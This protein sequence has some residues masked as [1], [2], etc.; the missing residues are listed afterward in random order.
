M[1]VK[2]TQKS[3]KSRKFN[4]RFTKNKVRKQKGGTGGNDDQIYPTQPVEKYTNSRGETFGFGNQPGENE[5]SITELLKK[6]RKGE[7]QRP[8]KNN[9]NAN[10]T[11]LF[12]VTINSSDQEDTDQFTFEDFITKR[13]E[14]KSKLCMFK[15]TLKDFDSEFQNYENIESILQQQL[16][17]INS[18]TSL[19]THGQDTKIDN[20][21]RLTI[22]NIENNEEL[23]G[24]IDTMNRFLNKLVC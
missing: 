5:T 14:F 12:N 9:N 22:K 10:N 11:S 1:T 23:R 17:S 16:S 4:K 18:S 24:L 2:I 13:E 21:L 19:I 3:S 20:A 7:L 8:N 15:Q 6:Y